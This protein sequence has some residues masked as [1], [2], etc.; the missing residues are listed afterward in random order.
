MDRRKII[1]GN[2]QSFTK[3]IPNDLIIE[4]LS[5]LTTKSIAICCCVSKQW[6][7]LLRTPYFTES[8]LT[9]SS[10]RPRILI[11]FQADGKW[12][13]FSFPQPRNLD[14]ELTRVEPDYHMSFSG[15]WDGKRC[16][17][18]NGFICRID[19]S[20][21]VDLRTFFGYD[22]IGKEYKVLCM[23][24]PRHS[25]RVNSKE[26]QVLTIGK[27][28]LSWRK[29]VCLF[30][31][32]PLNYHQAG[33]CINGVL[34][35]VAWSVPDKTSLIACF[36]VRSEEFRCIE[37]AEGFDKPYTSALVNYKGKLG[38]VIYVDGSHGELWVLDDTEKKKWSKHNFVLP[39]MSVQQI[40][41][42]WATDTDEIAWVV[43][44]P[45]RSPFCV[46]YSNLERKS[47]RRVVIEGID[48]QALMGNRR[49]SAQVTVRD[50]V[51]N[52]MFL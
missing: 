15:H 47:V 32:Y 27:G 16:L 42:T 5:R 51:E 19:I 31:H 12:H 34:Y 14:K 48:E 26:H 10:T 17:S 44:C 40:E 22:P 41:S 43:L 39:D 52:V 36:D 30:P 33:I 29:I 23:T 28:K 4:I 20:R 8:F 35:Y 37:M 1:R 9:R 3:T 25:Q 11:T 38:A 50:H 18:A 45:L 46:F 49:F 13:F 2:I 6:K 24:V 7:S 21:N